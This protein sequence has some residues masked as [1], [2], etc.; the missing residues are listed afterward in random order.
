MDL[1]GKH[2]LVTGGGGALGRAVADAVAVAGARV[3]RFDRAYPPA[4]AGRDDCRVV[5]LGDADAVAAAVAAATVTLGP[6]DALCNIAGGFD[7]GAGVADAD[8]AQ[9]QAMFAL[10]VATLRHMLKAVVPGM[11]ARHAGAVVN[12]GA[13]SAVS[14]KP[15]MSA[16]TASKA[17]VM[18][19]TEALAAEVAA[20]GVRANAVLPSI[21]DTPANR[22]AMPAADPAAWVA[23]TDIAAVICFL[24]SD[25]GR[26]INGALIPLAGAQGRHRMGA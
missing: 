2:V 11:R 21:I 8:D 3:T 4:L 14:G 9:W 17:V 23:A 12:V 18:N 16:Y 10:N 5:D 25:A 15:A 1:S 24:C 22:A 6:I 19:L 7:M 20:D 13:L 26:A